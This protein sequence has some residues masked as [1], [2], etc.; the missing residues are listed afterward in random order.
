MCK[1][2]KRDLVAGPTTST[3]P[4][5]LGSGVDN[6]ETQVL[7]P[8]EAQDAL[9]QLQSETS[10]KPEPSPQTS[11]EARRAEY[12]TA[13]GKVP[14]HVREQTP[15]LHAKTLES[16]E[17]ILP[18]AGQAQPKDSVCSSIYVLLRQLRYITKSS[19]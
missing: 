15:E 18:S 2:L 17:A 14:K 4:Q 19:I 16:G 10:P 11:A 13:S 1:L 6:H 12:A 7:A 9:Q 5:L 3:S 8:A